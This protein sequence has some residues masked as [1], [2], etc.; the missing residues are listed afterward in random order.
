MAIQLAALG[1][2][3]ILT[4]IM[5]FLSTLFAFFIKYIT[6]T[7]LIRIAVVT[8]IIAAFAAAI[9][10]FEQIIDSIY[11]LMPADVSKGMQLFIPDNVGQCLGAIATAHTTR[12]FY[13]LSVSS[14]SYKGR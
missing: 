10:A 4:V 5:G 13:I 12:M 2:G 7:L 11:M 3:Y 14:L 9:L 1:T 8:A 6:K